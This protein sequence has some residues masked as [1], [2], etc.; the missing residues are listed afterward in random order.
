M[1]HPKLEPA[2]EEITR[3]LHEEGR[4][5]EAAWE[6]ECVRRVPELADVEDDREFHRWQDYLAELDDMNADDVADDLAD[7]AY[8]LD[9]I[10]LG[11]VED[12]HGGAEY[13]EGDDS[14]DD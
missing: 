4:R 7:C 3:M 11:W 13:I 2:S 1:E 12:T 9:E 8:C 5:Q 10:S 6:R 14:D